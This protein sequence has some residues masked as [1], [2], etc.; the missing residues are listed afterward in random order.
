[1]SVPFSFY[2]LTS[3]IELQIGIVKRIHD[4]HLEAFSVLYCNFEGLDKAKVKRSLE[5][6]LR[7]SDSY[8]YNDDHFFFILYQTDKYGTTIVANMLE[9]FF[10][11]YIKHHVVSYPKDGETT[12]EM[13]ESMQV[14]VKKRFNQDLEC[15]D[16]STRERPMEIP[17]KA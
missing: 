5:E 11:T 15:L 4:N 7:S 12:Q 14:A 10:G 3:L 1:M 17:A 13:F 6:V 2:D 9:E 16:K 8:A